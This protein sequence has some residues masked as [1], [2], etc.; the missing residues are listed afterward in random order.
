MNRSLR[1]DVISV[2]MYKDLFFYKLIAAYAHKV[3]VKANPKK[4][5]S[6]IYT[7]V[8]HKKPNIDSPKD[9]I[10]KIYWLQLHSDTSL[11]TKCADKFRV[12][13]YIEECGLLDYMPKLYGKWDTVEEIPFD[14][15]PANYILKTNNGCCTCIVVRNGNVDR[16]KVKKSLRQWMQ[17]PYGYSGSQIHYT[18]IKPCIIAEELLENDEKDRRISPNSIIDYKIFCFNG[19]PECIWVAYDR[20]SH[21]ANMALFDTQWNAHPEHLVNI[22]SKTY[23][24]D[25]IIE[26]PKCLNEML[27]IARKLAKPFKEVRVDL[28]VIKDRPIIGELTFTSGYG[29]FT[30]DYYRYL[31]SKFEVGALE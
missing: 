12:R 10:E 2:I 1:F 31:G 29:F 27:D 9:L 16:E 30:E 6:R 24:P 7:K 11:W 4:E 23:L 25:I 5:M 18:R 19:E 20:N 13:E 28:Y 15:L 26:K 21:H 3:A 8:F 22:Q 14:S 17:I